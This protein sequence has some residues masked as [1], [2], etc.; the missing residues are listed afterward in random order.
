MFTKVQVDVLGAKELVPKALNKLS[1]PYC[2]IGLANK[3]NSGFE[4]NTVRSKVQ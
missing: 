3:D 4:G 1:N 2:V